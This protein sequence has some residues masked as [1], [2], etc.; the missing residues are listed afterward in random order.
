MDT[1]TDRVSACCRVQS[2][3]CAGVDAVQD[4]NLLLMFTIIM[5]FKNKDSAMVGHGLAGSRGKRVAVTVTL[6]FASLVVV[7]ATVADEASPQ[8][9]SQSQSE[10][11][12]SEYDSYWVGT[13]SYDM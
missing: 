4:E 7:L 12:N 6:L 13:A 10:R 3:G 9:Q 1:V 2:S 8:S 5:K 11:N